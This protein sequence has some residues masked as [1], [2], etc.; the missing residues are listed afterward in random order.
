MS[1]TTDTEGRFEF[2]GL[3]AG[4]THDVR[5]SA[6]GFDGYGTGKIK[7]TA[8]NT[9]DFGKITLL[10][11]SGV[12][13]GTVVDSSGKPVAAVRVFNSGDGARL[14][15]TLS[16]EA[17][18]FRLQGFHRGP[19]YVFAEKDGYRFTGLTTAA[20]TTGV[21]MTIP[22]N[23]E[24][25][26][27]VAKTPAPIF[28]EEKSARRV[29]ELLA[30][31]SD[32]GIKEQ[33]RRELAKLDGKPVEEEDDSQPG[34]QTSESP[35]G[36][37]VGKV[38]DED[39]EEALSLVPQDSYPAFCTLRDLAKRFV[40]SDPEKA[41]RFAAE[42]LIHARS[43]DDPLR[44]VGFGELGVITWQ[45]G[46]KEAGE[47]LVREAAD[48]AAKWASN[49][50]HEWQLISLAKNVAPVDRILA[51]GLLEK[52][53][54]ERRGVH[55][56]RLAVG[57]D[58]LEKAESVL[59]DVGPWYAGRARAR[60]AYRIAATR[61]A[62]AVRLVE[63]ISADRT[64]G[65]FIKVASFGWLASVIAAKDFELANSLIDR[66]FAMYLHPVDRSVY[67]RDGVAGQAAMLAFHAKTA[68]YPDMES[69]IYR[70]LAIRPTTNDAASPVEAKESSA[71]MAAFLSFVDR[72][73]A[74]QMLQAIEPTSDTLGSADTGF[75]RRDWLRAWAL[76]DPPH[77]VELFERE[78]AAA[79]DENS[80]RSAWY[81]GLEMVE[82]WTG[83]QSNIVKL[84][85]RGN[86]NVFSPDQEF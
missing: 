69:V 41:L 38:A 73:L 43:I 19:V 35:E 30:A 48:M 78:L 80:K 25:P 82:F 57:L 32:D 9:R 4:E 53:K 58:D 7:G 22:R 47:K 17:G 29:L 50:Q 59:Q 28:K 27:P 44:T 31:A 5:I 11:I 52:L 81:A 23:D 86:G 49:E 67:V 84:I 21:V 36:I 79:K 3:W 34:P 66:A 77:A 37:D 70:V 72:P 62:E 54:K 76:V 55:V 40:K 42:A 15:E 8:G 1:C 68:G 14:L 75:Q 61:P 60:L 71:V 39:V 46:N 13:D 2:G 10:G 33:A 24:P 20:D 51:I 6:R 63:N 12:V 56:A 45:A 26:P 65:E 16:D 18:K 85:T 74:K 83:D 64:R